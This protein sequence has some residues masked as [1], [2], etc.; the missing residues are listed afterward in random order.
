MA[1]I[2]VPGE[3]WEVEFVSYGA[4]VHVE[5][6]RFRND[7]AIADERMLEDLFSKYAD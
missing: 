3:R 6:E 1:E 7:G 4:E 2:V 5:I